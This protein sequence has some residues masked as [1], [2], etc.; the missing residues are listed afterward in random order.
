[1]ET[2]MLD[3]SEDT[4]LTSRLPSPEE[5]ESAA[6]SATALASALMSARQDEGAIEFRVGSAPPV[7]MAPAIAEI[8]VDL[9]GH[10]ASGKMVEFVPTGA[11]LTTQQAADILNVSRSFLVKLLMDGEIPYISTGT[12]RRILHADLM[13]YRARR[14]FGRNAA[15]EELARL[16]QEIDAS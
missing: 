3:S 8:V 1:M 2:D 7:R 6:E 10:V 13:E 14:D 11:I 12:Q 15:L 4:E 16:G 5:T 9:L